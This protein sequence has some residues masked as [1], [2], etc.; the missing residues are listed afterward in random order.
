MKIFSEKQLRISLL[1]VILL[2]ALGLATYPF[3]PLAVYYFGFASIDTPG[4]LPAP[5][6]YK[7][8][9]DI[10]AQGPAE[11]IEGNRIAI[12]KIGVLMPITGG[13]NQDYAWALGAWID[14]ST[15]TPDKGSNTAL[16]AHRF[17]Y[18]PPHSKTFYLL[19]KLEDGDEVVVYWEGEKYTYEVN[20]S[21]IV[22]PTA[23]EVLDPTQSPTLTLITCTPLFSTKNRLVVTAELV[24]KVALK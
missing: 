7:E 23:V 24:N 1:A 10:S 2:S 8:G 13:E 6:E 11:I 3:W 20:N 18:Q 22:K 4:V 21:K 17:R 5:I 19:D 9:G 16:S 15:S 12:P 14:P